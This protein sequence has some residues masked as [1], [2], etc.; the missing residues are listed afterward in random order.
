[1]CDHYKFRDHVKMSVGFFTLTSGQWDQ[2]G[3][4]ADRGNDKGDTAHKQTKGSQLKRKAK[5]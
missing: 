3:S 2:S 5:G 4:V 1:M